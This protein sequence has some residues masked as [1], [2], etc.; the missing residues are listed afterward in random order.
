[1]PPFY[2]LHVFPVGVQPISP[3]E[4]GRDPPTSLDIGSMIG[5]RIFSLPDTKLSKAGPPAVSIGWAQAQPARHEPLLRNVL[6][7]AD[8]KSGSTPV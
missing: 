5:S 2:A 3:G 4:L 7:P 8:P 6:E 1:M